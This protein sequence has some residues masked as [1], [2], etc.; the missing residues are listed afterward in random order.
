MPGCGLRQ[1]QVARGLLR[2]GQGPLDSEE[3]IKLF[4]PVPCLG[5]N[6][7]IAAGD[8]LAND[9]ANL[10]GMSAGGRAE[11]KSPRIRLEFHQFDQAAYQ[12][13]A[14]HGGSLARVFGKVK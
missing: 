7:P 10:R 4:A 5:R 3:L 8:R 13:S 14:E 2:V 6:K 9:G 12:V 1:R 11:G